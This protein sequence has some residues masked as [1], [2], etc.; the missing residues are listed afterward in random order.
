M[1]YLLLSLLL[2]VSCLLSIT[3]PGVAQSSKDAFTDDDMARAIEE[4]VDFLWRQRQDDGS[5]GDYQVDKHTYRTG[6]TAL[7]MYALLETGV[8]PQE[9][10]MAKS[11]E[12]LSKNREADLMTYSIGLRAN[13]WAAAN[14]ETDGKYIKELQEDVELL[15]RGTKNGWYSYEID[16]EDPYD[17]GDNSNSQFAVLGA[18]AG[19]R[20]N[21]EI[22]SGYW[23]TIMNH[24]MSVQNH[25]GGWDYRGE[26][27]SYGPMTAGGVA[28][29]FV[30]FDSLFSDAFIRCN[31][32]HEVEMRAINNG[33][34]WLGREFYRSLER[35]YGNEDSYFYYYM[36]A[37]ERAGLASGYK[38]F[39]KVDWFQAGTSRILKLQEDDG[40]WKNS[41]TSRTALA[42]LFLQRGRHPILFNKLE[43]DADWNN[44]PRELANLTR[45]ISEVF[46][47]TVNWQIVTLE[48]PVGDW[49]DAPILYL[50]ASRPPKFTDADLAKLR[51]YAL[52]GG[53]ILSIT[54][55]R[56]R[57]FTN[58]MMQVYEK[59]F[60]EYKIETVPDDHP[61]RTIQF[62]PKK[63]A[64]L[65]W[66]TNGL[67]PLAIHCDDDL[68]LAWQQNH[69]TT[70][71]DKF[72]TAANIYLY[73]TNKGAL[74]YRG[75]KLWPD[76][77]SLDTPSRTIKVVRIKHKGHWN[78]EPLALQRFARLMAARHS[79]KIEI[80]D[81]IEPQDLPNSQADMAVLTGMETLR[82]NSNQE[83]ALKTYADN[84]GLL[85]IDAAAGEQAFYRSARDMLDKLYGPTAFTPLPVDAPIYTV[86]GMKIGKLNY[87]GEAA[88][89]HRGGVPALQG[90]MK[91]GKLQVVFSREDITAGLVGYEC[92]GI[93]GY[94]PEDAFSIMRNAAWLAAE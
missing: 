13:V 16:P 31:V 72:E 94:A 67:R 87:R 36:Y 23:L 37:I 22:P 41:N 40:S 84:G 24:W 71:R 4:G 34:K 51:E 58:G 56:G 78:P 74:R 44:R 15:V 18:W 29:L 47:G 7:V 53:T 50:S 57:G 30:C 38:Y 11:L 62:R 54:E 61:L 27:N 2:A 91:D 55:C 28:T 79:A 45:W 93:D 12:W 83:A 3:A 1:K 73:C 9:E 10:R 77:V 90:V 48:S 43:F 92:F 85:V 33:L 59:I 81:P 70:Q 63:K 49:H 39:G 68:P 52:Q 19:K 86:P 88:A 21:L 65:K 46:E 32:S 25:D 80:L 17:W 42:L 82:L 66:I 14:Q 26:G 76:P 5:W 35:P 89:R 8:S 75:V 20:N 69:T 60:P 6:L 64:D